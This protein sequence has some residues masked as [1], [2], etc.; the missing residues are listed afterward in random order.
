MSDAE[1]WIIQT[2]Q[3]NPRDGYYS[4]PV[5]APSPT[6][7]AIGARSFNWVYRNGNMPNSARRGL[8]TPAP[9]VMFGHA[10]NLVEWEEDGVPVRRV[11]VEEA[12]TLQTF[13]PDHPWQGSRT[14]QFEQIGNAIP[15][16]LA[17]HLLSAATG[18]SINSTEQEAA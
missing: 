17:G 6:V 8:D 18:I 14:K 12:A 15:P 2:N 4:R 1:G 10:M 7:T 13:P 16:V 3:G 9:T 5:T 11:T